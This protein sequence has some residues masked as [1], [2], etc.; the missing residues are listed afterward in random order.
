MLDYEDHSQTCGVLQIDRTSS[1][2][3]TGSP[4]E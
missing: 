4:P 2:L 3:S 1:P